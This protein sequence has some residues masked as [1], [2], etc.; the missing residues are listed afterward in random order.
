MFNT[1]QT[2]VQ[3]I[4]NMGEKIWTNIGLNIIDS[5]DVNLYLVMG[6]PGVHMGNWK[7]EETIGSELGS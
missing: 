4:V 3:K 7:H 6:L 2:R 5:M 1:Y